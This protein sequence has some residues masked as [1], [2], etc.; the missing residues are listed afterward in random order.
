MQWTHDEWWFFFRRWSG[1]GGTNYNCTIIQV[2]NDETNVVN[3][4]ANHN[5]YCTMEVRSVVNLQK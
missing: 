4:N 5:K 2:G 3:V 1:G